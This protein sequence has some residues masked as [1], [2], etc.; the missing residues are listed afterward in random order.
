MTRPLS[1]ITSMTSASPLGLGRSMYPRGVAATAMSSS[2]IGCSCLAGLLG[3]QRL[4]FVSAHQA[5]ADD[6]AVLRQ[7]LGD[8]GLADAVEVADRPVE[9]LEGV[10]RRHAIAVGLLLLRMICVLRVLALARH[11]APSGDRCCCLPGVPAA[12][13]RDP[14]A[15]RAP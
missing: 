10:L 4:F 7:R 12:G 6:R 13:W 11:G 1:R 5:L 9:L 2:P 15:R 8:L 3:G 14:R